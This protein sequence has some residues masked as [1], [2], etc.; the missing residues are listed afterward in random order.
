MLDLLEGETECGSSSNSTI[1]LICIPLDL[2]PSFTAALGAC[3][4]AREE[5][6]I[7]HVEKLFGE[8]L[9]IALISWW[10]SYPDMKTDSQLIVPFARRKTASNWVSKLPKPPSVAPATAP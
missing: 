6:G 8:L 5:L 2:T 10:A 1:P 4:V 7:G 9:S 3:L